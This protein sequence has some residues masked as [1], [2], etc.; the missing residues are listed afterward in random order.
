MGDFRW[1]PWVGSVWP[2]GQDSR[3]S[4][5]GKWQ[6]SLGQVEVPQGSRPAILSTPGVCC[7]RHWASTLPSPR[8]LSQEVPLCPSSIPTLLPSSGYFLRVLCSDCPVQ[9]MPCRQERGQFPRCPGTRHGHLSR[10][11]QKGTAPLMASSCM[12]VQSRIAQGAGPAWQRR[13]GREE[14]V[15]TP[16]HQPGL[17]PGQGESTCPDCGPHPDLDTR[18]CHL[19]QLLALSPGHHRA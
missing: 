13:G 14:G 9:E 4:G 5:A 17:L 2:K 8:P 1:H 19:P 7:C 3:H 10:C 11:A 16:T 6:G 15:L 12:P 18:A